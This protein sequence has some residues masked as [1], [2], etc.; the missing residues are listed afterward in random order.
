MTESFGIKTQP[1]DVKLPI[2]KAVGA[3]LGGSGRLKERGEDG[4]CGAR[5]VSY[6]A[7]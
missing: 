5:I 4:G 2:P 1:N 6:Q 3:M 7:A